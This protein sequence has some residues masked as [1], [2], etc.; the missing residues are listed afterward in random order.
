MRQKNPFLSFKE[1]KFPKKIKS[2]SNAIDCFC[3]FEKQKCNNALVPIRIWKFT[4]YFR[5]W[6]MQL[7]NQ[8]GE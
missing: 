3:D 7:L 1:Q 2:T 6:A 5:V 4:L 8:I